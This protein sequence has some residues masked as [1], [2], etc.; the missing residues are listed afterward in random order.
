[1]VSKMAQVYDVK[2]IKGSYLLFNRERLWH[3][4]LDVVGHRLEYLHGIGFV[5][6]D[7]DLVGNGLLYW[8]GDMLL[9]NDMVGL[10]H[11]DWVGL[12]DWH[13]NLIR[14]LKT[15]TK[16][17]STLLPQRFENCTFFITV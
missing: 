11:M 3:R 9:N 4:D 6:G 16:L 14:H 10:G 7:L 1:M 5:H 12:V 15:K 13:L 8:Y 17:L 2:V